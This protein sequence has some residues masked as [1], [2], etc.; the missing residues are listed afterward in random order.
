MAALAVALASI[1]APTAS[2]QGSSTDSGFISVGNFPRF[3]S[4]PYIRRPTVS[5]EP[6]F[7]DKETE[8]QW[9]LA[10]KYGMPFAG[11]RWSWQLSVPVEEVNGPG[12]QA[13]GLS[14][15]EGTVNREI[16]RGAWKQALS[17]QLTANTATN[18]LLGGGQ[19]EIMPT[20]AIGHWLSPLFSA[21]M[22]LSWQ[23]GFLV[24][25]GKT[26]TDIIE[27]RILFATHLDVIGDL[28]SLDLR[29]RFD[30]TRNE[31]YSTL[32]PFLSG[33]LGPHFSGQ[34]G[35][36]FPLSQ[37]AAKRVENSRVYVDISHGW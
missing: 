12:K 30:L 21:G 1:V 16:S 6:T 17:L 3:E 4:D 22:L 25:D 37:L 33:S 31:F 15:V 34:F 8:Q 27:P 35:F 5:A 20:Y 10:L 14:D 13:I 23:Y 2:A 7:T 9:E 19:W 11:D 24:E 29:P 36:E 26:Q 28:L 18:D 32:M